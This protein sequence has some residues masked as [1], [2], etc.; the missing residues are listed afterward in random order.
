MKIIDKII[1]MSIVD[2][3]FIQM[4]IERDKKFMIIH[5]P[6]IF[7]ISCFWITLAGISK[8]KKWLE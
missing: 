3:V 2:A 5:F 6:Q 7:L 8:L 4:D 1:K